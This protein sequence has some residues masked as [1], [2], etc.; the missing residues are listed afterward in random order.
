MAFA[1]AA[2]ATRFNE[3]CSWS[4]WV[5]F[6]QLA[7]GR[8]C[9]ETV[10]CLRGLFSLVGAAGSVVRGRLQIVGYHV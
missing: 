6:Q 5:D 1:A 4:R 7:H 2:A 8:S 9:H 3:S 10:S